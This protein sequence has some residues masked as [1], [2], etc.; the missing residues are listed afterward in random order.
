MLSQHRGA[1]VGQPITHSLSPV[2]HNAAYAALGLTDW[3]YG[4]HEVPAGGL[5][6]FVAGLDS[7]WVGLSVTMPLKRE[8]LALATQASAR[9]Q[10]IGAANTLIFKAEEIHADNTDAPGMVDAI[11]EVGMGRA[12]NMVIIGGGGTAQAALGAAVDLTDAPVHILVRDVNRAAE[13]QASAE[14]LA[15]PLR[16]LTLDRAPELL[17]R[18][19]LVVSTVPAGA[20]DQFVRWVPPHGSV[21]FD[22]VYDPWPTPFAAAARNAGCRIVSGLDLLLHQ[23]TYQVTAMTGQRAPLEAMRAALTEAVR[24]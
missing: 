12:S 3:H 6:S 21:V 24:R 7:Q 23:A 11:A 9:A 17:S 18:A 10:A 15:V 1:S 4:K 16:V 8:A 22:V 14:R 13:A 20:A 2:L 19:D 5:A